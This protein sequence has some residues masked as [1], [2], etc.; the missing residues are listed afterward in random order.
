[1]KE[2]VAQGLDY[3]TSAPVRLFCHASFAAP[4]EAVFAKL[5]DPA[6]WPTWFP[7]MKSAAWVGE[8]VATL[9]ADR[10]VALTG[11]G[12]FR[13]RMIAWEPGKRFAFTMVQS[14]SPFASAMAEDYKLKATAT[15]TQLDWIMAVTPTTLG[16]IAV[17]GLRIVMRNIFERGGK[18]LNAQLMS[19]G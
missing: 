7:M 1:M 15:G 16:K 13:E 2:L 4:P 9:G 12:R 14:S 19:G 3:F 6:S 18:R 10:D 5:A 8:P 17:P 11:L